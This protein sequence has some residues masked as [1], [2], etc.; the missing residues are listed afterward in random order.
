MLPTALTVHFTGR[1]VLV[2]GNCLLSRRPL[3]FLRLDCL[4]P[5]RFSSRHSPTGSFSFSL[6]IFQ[7]WEQ[8][9][10]FL[11]SRC[12]LLGSMGSSLVPFSMLLQTGMWL[13]TWRIILMSPCFSHGMA[14]EWWFL[15][16]SNNFFFCDYQ[17]LFCCVVGM[18]SNIGKT[19]GKTVFW[20]L[21]V[22]FLLVGTGLMSFKSK[23]RLVVSFISHLQI[24]REQLVVMVASLSTIETSFQFLFFCLMEMLLS[25][26]VIGSLKAIRF[27]QRFFIVSSLFCYVL[28]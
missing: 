7:S 24:S 1:I 8:C 18:G 6:S 26:S 4:L 28:F 10:K 23:T 20:A 16:K 14:G 27:T 21:T 5:H 11:R 2:G 22:L 17:T 12:R 19:R 15:F 25:L 3:R 13:W 9:I